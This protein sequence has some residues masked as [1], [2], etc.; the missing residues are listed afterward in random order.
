MSLMSFFSVWNTSA[1][2]RRPSLKDGAPAGMTMNSWV[3]TELSAWAPPFSMFIIGT[4]RLLPCTPP[5]N[6]C[7]VTPR[8]SLAAFAAAMD[9]ASMAFAPRLLLSLVPS[10][11]SIA[12]STA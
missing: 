9:T 11:L 5:R 8:P 1:H 4:G 6:W 12:P 10:A 3:S 2:Q 7:S